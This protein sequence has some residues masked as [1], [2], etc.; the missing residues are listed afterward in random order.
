[1][2]EEILAM[3]GGY[4]APVAERGLNLAGGQKQRIALARIFLKNLPIL[5]LDGATS[6]RDA[7]SERKVQQA[8]ASARKDRTVILVAHRL[9]TLRHA[10]RVAVFEDGRVVEV[11][12]YLERGGTFAELVRCAGDGAE[13]KGH[14]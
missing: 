2:H 3:P 9:S 12:S 11:G 10:D 5:V 4:Q 14:P 6:A 1:L 8:I 7:I 13:S